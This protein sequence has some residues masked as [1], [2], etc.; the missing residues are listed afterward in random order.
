MRKLKVIISS[1]VALATTVLASLT[2]FADTAPT[3]PTFDATAPMTNGMN[4]IV[5][6]VFSMFGVVMPY[7]LTILAVGVG[8][9]VAIG[10]FK[11]VAR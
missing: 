8:V 7:A 3:I 10:L 4:A 1:V 9:R 11:R 6:S 2:A 5:N